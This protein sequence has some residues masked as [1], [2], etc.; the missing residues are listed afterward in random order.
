VF[1]RPRTTVL[2]FFSPEYVHPA[3]WT[4]SSQ[5]DL[6]YHYLVGEG[7]PPEGRSGFPE[8]GTGQFPLHVDPDRLVALLKMAGL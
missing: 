4:L 2:E 3:F 1:C 6:D 5:C 8:S 7:E